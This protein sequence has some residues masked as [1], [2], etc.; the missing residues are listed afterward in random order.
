MCVNAIESGRH[1][2][3][4]AVAGPGHGLQLLGEARGFAFVQQAG[5]HGTGGG[6]NRHRAALGAVQQVRDQFL[7]LAKASN[8]PNNAC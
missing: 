5:R 4:G 2:R 8:T 6:N 7:S 3:G 1:K